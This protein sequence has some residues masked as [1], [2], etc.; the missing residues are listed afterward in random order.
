VAQIY[1]GADKTWAPNLKVL[2][3]KVYCLSSTVGATADI[4]IN[5]RATSETVRYL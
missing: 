3:F 1:I 4:P 2:A 5:L